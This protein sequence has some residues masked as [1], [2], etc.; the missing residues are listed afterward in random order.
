MRTTVHL[1]SGTTITGTE[2]T[3]AELFDELGGESLENANKILEL[4]ESLVNFQNS[5]QALSLEIAGELHVIPVENVDFLVLDEYQKTVQ[6]LIVM[7]KS[8]GWD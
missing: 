7:A 2:Q 6:E 8:N 3:I 4:F 1:K 5:D